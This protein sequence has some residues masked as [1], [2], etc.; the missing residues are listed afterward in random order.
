MNFLRM[1]NS[2][3]V[4]ATATV[5]GLSIWNVSTCL[6]AQPTATGVQVAPQGTWSGA[7]LP[8]F[9]P[10]PEQVAAFR[11]G[12]GGGRGR[13]GGAA[14]G[15]SG[16]YMST[17]Q[18]HWFAGNAKLWYR[19]DLRDD[20]KQFMLVDAERGTRAPAF[21]HRKLAE[22][23]SK[24]S[25]T[26]FLENHLPFDEIEFD[27]A[28][29]K[30]S[31]TAAGGRWSCDLASYQVT[32]TGDAPAREADGERGSPR[33]QRGRGGRGGGGGGRRGAAGEE[34]TPE[35]SADGTNLAYDPQSRSQNARQGNLYEDARSPDGKWTALI[36]ENNIFL[37]DANGQE[38]RLSDA[39]EAGNSF[40]M[41]SWSPDSKLLVG[42][43]IVPKEK[44]KVYLIVSSPQEGGRAQLRERLYPLPGDPYTTYELWA[45]DVANK[46]GVKV[47]AERIDFYGD[48]AIRWRADNQHFLY[49]KTDRGHG[50]FRIFDV[51]ALTGKV[52]TLFDDD[53]ETFVHT[54]TN[55]FIRYNAGNAEVIYVSEK[56]GWRHLYLINAASGEVKQITKGNW[57]VRGVD[58]VDEEKRKIWFRAGGLKPDQD[59]YFIH[60][61]RVN[62]DG[63]GFVSLTEGNGTHSIQYSPDQ[64]YIIDT[65]SRIDAPPTHEL[66]RVEDGKLVTKLEQADISELLSTG[67]KLPEVL[68]AKG[69]DGKTD[70]WGIL[71][72]PRNFDPNKRYPVIE[73][74]YAGPHSSYVP[75]AFTG[76][77]R[78]GTLTDLGFMVSKMDGMG[79]ANRSKAFHDVCWQNIADAGFADR[80]LWHKAAAAKYP[81]YDISR[82]GLYGGSAGGQNSV[83]ALL[84]H[85]EFYKVAVSSCGCH[86]QRMDKASWNEQYMGY[87]VGSKYAENSNIEHAAKLKGKLLLILGEL[88]TNVPPETT[89]RLIDAL[90]RAGKD[91]EFLHVPNAGHGSGG[92]LGERRRVDF[93]LRH[94]HG[95]DPPDRNAGGP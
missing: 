92:A 40:G 90:N 5:S 67:Y 9:K 45:F 1:K 72:R 66:R 35:T 8:A 78:W 87:P 68:V 79:T 49:H 13:G 85:P 57:L 44:R 10:T 91:Y 88:D 41:M 4:V 3:L 46:K 23:L 53:P 36:K 21:D 63:T 73:D 74:I 12:Q 43:R 54:T 80:I 55:S 52:R 15:P 86:D 24:A 69:R 7:N 82:V 51:D 6:H 11:P 17:I 16:V 75:K 27:D 81:Y 59:P 25:G 2:V 65:Y 62:F 58:R 32:R 39:G 14:A 89:F 95:I 47:D 71:E 30:V 18:P 19:N 50:R 64:K 61:C 94:L 31:F 70:I 77:P 33:G 48:P 37:R 56:D 83:G 20:V 84:F 22:A 26:D 29:T 76:R 42:M 60:Y 34:I 38:T 28:A 93:F